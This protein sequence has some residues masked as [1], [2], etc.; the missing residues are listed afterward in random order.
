MKTEKNERK[1]HQNET[2]TKERPL[3]SSKINVSAT[4]H[5]LVKFYAT[6]MF[7]A[8]NKQA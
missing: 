3:R 6:E 4:K 8:A 1:Q 5:F 7:A 2:H